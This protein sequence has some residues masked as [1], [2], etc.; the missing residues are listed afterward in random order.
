MIRFSIPF[1]WGYSA[2][3]RDERTIFA[4]YTL[5]Y[6]LCCVFNFVRR[7]KRMYFHVTSS[8]TFVTRNAS[9]TIAFFFLLVRCSATCQ[10]LSDSQFKWIEE[11]KVKQKVFLIELGPGTGDNQAKWFDSSQSSSFIGLCRPF[12][13]YSYLSLETI[14][15]DYSVRDIDFFSGRALRFKIN[16]LTSQIISH[17]RILSRMFL[18]SI[19]YLFRCLPLA[20]FTWNRTRKPK[21]EK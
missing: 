11:F 4:S 10:F 8:Q 1:R 14:I 12:H 17:H 6:C 16:V 13:W 20:L 21:T 18:C 3:Q 2:S 9:Q 5:L 15:M 7:T 19:R